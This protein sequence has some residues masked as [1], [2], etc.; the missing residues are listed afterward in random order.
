MKNLI[1]LIIPITILFV[2]CNNPKYKNVPISHGNPGEL[3]IVMSNESFKSEAGDTLRAI[4]HADCP[5]VPMEENIMDMYQIPYN[6][7]IE[8]NLYHRNIIFQEIKPDAPEAKITIIKDRYAQ[9][10]I[11]VNVLAPNQAEFVKIVS[12]NR[13]NLVK[14]F[15]EADRDRWVNQLL[16]QNNKTISKKIL[17]KYSVSIT[18]P[19]NYVLSEYRDEFAWVSNETKYY[20]MNILVYTWP[21]SD[22]SSLDREYLIAMRNSVLKENIP[23]EREGS[24]MSTETKY[25]YPYYELISH[26]NQETGILRGCWKVQGDFMGGPFVSYTKFDRPRN[27]MVCVEGFVYHPNEETRDKI[28]LLEGPLFTFDL[29]K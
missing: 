21:I 2:A 12:K 14:L 1:L 4:F 5:G 23:G 29:V 13:D 18:I 6:E 7:F 15:V 11:F 3:V 19:T 9:K 10:Q 22:T 28:R 17:D 25:D 16:Q 24:H 26:K 8:Q 20:S 27:R